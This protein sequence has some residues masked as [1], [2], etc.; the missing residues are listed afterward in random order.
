MI[1]KAP[2]P[3]T[4]HLSPRPPPRLCGSLFFQQ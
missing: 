1:P 3:Q 2:N 4:H